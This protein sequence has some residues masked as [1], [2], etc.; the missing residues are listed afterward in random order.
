VREII[1]N[2][3]WSKFKP[4]V[5]VEVDNGFHVIDGQH[6][7][8]A[9]ASHPDVRRI[10]V[11]V[12]EAGSVQARAAAFLGHNRN[13]IS[14]TPLQLFHASVAAGDPDALTAQ[15]VCDRA[16]VKISTSQGGNNLYHPN[17]TPSPQ[18]IAAMAKRKPRHDPSPSAPQAPCAKTLTQRGRYR[19]QHRGGHRRLRHRADHCRL[20]PV[21][22]MMTLQLVLMRQA[23]LVWL[24]LA[25]MPL[26]VTF[27][28]IEDELHARGVVL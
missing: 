5:V 10:P 27:D 25:L 28:L 4:P 20:L 1:A 22:Q 12:V 6:T 3:D 17:E 13:R 23:M 24:T 14:I 8:I 7:A 2:W 18:V 15:Q 16:G 21:R 9:A 11:M 19:R 26:E